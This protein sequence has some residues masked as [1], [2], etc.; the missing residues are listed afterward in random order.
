MSTVTSRDGTTIAYSRAGSGPALILVDGALCSRAFGPMPGYAKLLADQFTVYWYDRRG[1]GESGDAA[2]YAIEREVED[3][4]A[5]LAATG[6]SAYVFGA[7]SGAA[8][9]LQGVTRGLSITKLLMYEAPY[10]PV[11]AG[12]KTAAQHVAA[13]WKLV[14]AGERGAAVRYFMCDVV[15]MPKVMGYLFALFPMWPKLKAAAYAL[16]Y[17]LTIMADEDLLGARSAQVKIPV[18]VAG[19]AKSPEALKA[20]VRKVASAI[21]TSTTK[22]LEG[23]THNL[24]AAPAAAMAREFFLAH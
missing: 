18:L 2:T 4:A 24:G 10:V 8:L 16:P 9:G 12:G 15:G 1:R 21:P 23:Q 13:L 22:W 3:L 5:L 7:S 20:A 19:G 11:P 6:G 17:D 14:G